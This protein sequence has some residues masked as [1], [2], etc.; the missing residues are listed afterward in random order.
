[1]GDHANFKRRQIK[2]HAVITGAPGTGKTSLIS[3]LQE[4]VPC[5]P[6]PARRV[7]ETARR[8]GTD[9]TGDRNPVA[10]LEAMRAMMLNDL[11]RAAKLER[12]AAFDRSLPD[13]IAYANWYESIEGI[14]LPDHLT[15][16]NLACLCRHEMPN[17]TAF[18]CPVWDE[19]YAQDDER[20][21]TLADSYNFES[22]LKTAYKDCQFTNIINVPKS[23]PKERA[24]FIANAMGF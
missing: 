14:S 11:Q 21:M 17:F 3:Y 10:F 1:M 23:T 15:P 4:R 7:I 22:M 16:E 5:I 8:F 19:I 24:E 20:Q 6:E 9:A 13:L 2:P 12:P 18:H